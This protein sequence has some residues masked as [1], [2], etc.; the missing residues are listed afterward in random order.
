MMF[1]ESEGE[2]KGTPIYIPPE[3]WKDHEYTK[4]GDVYAFAMIS[5][6]MLTLEEPFKGLT[7]DQICQKV[8]VEGQRPE[9][10]FPLAECY[11]SLIERCWSQN[12]EDR[13]TF[14]Q[15]VDELKYN[16]EFIKDID[17]QEQFLDYIDLIDSNKSLIDPSKKFKKVTLINLS[18]CEK[19]I[20]K[21]PQKILNQNTSQNENNVNEQMVN[22]TIVPWDSDCYSCQHF[23]IAVFGGVCSGKTCFIWMFLEG[24]FK[25]TY[26]P[27]IE[28]E[29]KT[30]VVFNGQTI[31]L[32]ILDTS[33]YPDF[34]PMQ[35]AYMKRNDGFIILYSV[36]ERDTL[37]YAEDMIKRIYKIRA[38]FALV[39]KELLQKKKVKK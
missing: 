31:N 5:Y 11:K 35:R 14:E 20:E 19:I 28:D 17:D 24:K 33:G 38:I 25:P 1:S 39:K 15:I 21:H 36:K 32:K 37:E 16:K 4:A 29:Y 6:E 34:I 18:K 10:K 3:S 8:S 22:M 2:V 26:D 23:K 9:F 13:P 27:T 7:I 12:P 30:G